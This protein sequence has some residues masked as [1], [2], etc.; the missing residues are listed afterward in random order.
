[1]LVS[2]TVLWVS[3][4]EVVSCADEH[5]AFPPVFFYQIW[6]YLSHVESLIYLDLSV[7]QDDG[8]GSVFVVLRAAIVRPAALVE[9][10]VLSSV[11]SQYSITGVCL[12]VALALLSM[13][14]F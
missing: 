4:Q 3:V 6:G 12:E 7:V 11:W 13:A 1:M 2:V 14:L 10:A 9:E 5:K 8:Y